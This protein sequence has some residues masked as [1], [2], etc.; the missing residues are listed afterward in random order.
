MIKKKGQTIRLDTPNTTMVLR[1]DT[2]EY[3]YYGSRLVSGGDL[4]NIPGSGRR[5]LST[6]GAE[7]YSEYSLLLQGAGGGFAAD[8]I[9][10]KAR[11]LAAKPELPGFPLPMVRGR[12][13]NSNIRTAPRA[14]PS[15]CTSP[16]MT[17]ATS[18]P[19]RRA[20]STTGAKRSASAA[21]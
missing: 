16:P 12:R 20:W 15:T 19:S 11:V 5:F 6:F 14:S 2:A 18:S 4:A 13:S 3:L 1:T 10:S 9:F 7:D 21:S 8:F 17:T